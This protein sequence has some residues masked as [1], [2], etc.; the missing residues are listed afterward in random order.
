M[1]KT[2][3]GLIVAVEIAL[4]SGLLIKYFPTKLLIAAALVAI[5][6][7]HVGLA[8]IVNTVSAMDFRMSNSSPNHYIF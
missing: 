6:F 4:L 8:L 1:I 7:L 5:A 3:I 2:F